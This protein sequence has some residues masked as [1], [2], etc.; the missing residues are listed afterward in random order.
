[1]PH[2][3]NNNIE[4][5]LYLCDL[6]HFYYILNMGKLSEI[7]LNGYWGLSSGPISSYTVYCLCVVCT[8][9]DNGRCAYC[10]TLNSTYSYNM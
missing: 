4:F 5:F 2:N 10:C 3:E 9:V 7:A 6:V 8:Y 1:M